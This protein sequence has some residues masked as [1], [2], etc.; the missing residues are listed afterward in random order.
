MPRT[1]RGFILATTLLV[2]TMLTVMLT[3]AFVM[4]SA[5]YRSTNGSY[6]MAR[7]L[8]F[9]QAGLQQYFSEAHT[10]STGATSD[11]LNY[12]Y[13][14]GYARVV[15]RRL[16]DSISGE[17]QVWI[18]YATGLDTTRTLTTSG[19]GSRVVAQLAQLY[20]GSIPARAA[21]TAANGVIMQGSGAQPINGNNFG[22]TWS[23]CTIPT[24]PA[25]DTTGLTA[26]VVGGYGGSSGSAPSSIEYLLTDAAVIDS[27]H[28]NWEALLAGQ[29]TP[30]VVGSLP[31]NCTGSSCTFKSYYFDGNVTVTSGSKRGLLVATGNVALDASA[32]WDGIIVAGGRLDTP[33]SG[34]YTVHGMVIAGRKIGVG[35]NVVANSIR[36]GSSGVIR[37]DYCYATKAMGSLSYLVPITGTYTDSWKTY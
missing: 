1:D 19:S 24:S 13:S 17:R 4:I 34:N 35:D 37:W 5:E 20:A 29:F 25:D 21:M 14:G 6:A 3:A 32:H 12:T 33:N 18:V 36:G 23:G 30:D 26:P 7:A 2:M 10:F 22:Q 27:T 8:N 9:A 16:R 11:S 15:A 28:I 31:A